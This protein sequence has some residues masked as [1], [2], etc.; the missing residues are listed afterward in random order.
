M[1][2]KIKKYIKDNCNGSYAPDDMD[3]L[4]KTISE[5]S[6]GCFS[7]KK[8]KRLMCH[9][10]E[11]SSG[12]IV[13]N[14]KNK[15]KLMT[16]DALSEMCETTGSESESE[17][18]DK[19]TKSNSVGMLRL[20]FLG[21]TKNPEESKPV[22]NKPDEKYKYPETES[23]TAICRNGDPNYGPFS[24][25]SVHDVQVDDKLSKKHK[26][27][28]KAFEYLS[29]IE[30]PEQR[31]DTWFEQRK[32]KI[33]A[34][35]G[36]MVVGVNH[37]EP[38]WKFVCKKVT[39]PPFQNNVFCYH[40]K[41]LE[42]IATMVY[43]YR[44]NVKV[45]EFGMVPHKTIDFLGA[46]PDGIVSPYKLDSKHLTREVGKM[47]EI[48]CPY[49]RKI[50]KVGNIKG[51]I[52]PIYYWVQVQLQLECCDLDEC[53]FWQCEIA[54]YDDM[55]DFEDDTDPQFPYLSKD[56]KM[57]KGALIQLLPFNDPDFIKDKKYE[58]NSD[59]YYDKV[60]ASAIFIYPPK[61]EMTP[62]D[63]SIWV[64]STCANIKTSHPQYYLD[65]VIYWKMVVTHNVTIPRDKEWFEEHL[66]M[67]RK[68]WKYV[69]Y[70][71][72]NQDKANIVFEYIESLGMK[73]RSKAECD[74]ND[75]IMKIYDTVCDEPDDKAPEKEHRKYAKHIAQIIK[76]TCTNLSK[77]DKV[78]KDKQWKEVYEPLYAGWDMAKIL[79]DYMASL[80][81]KQ[82]QNVN[83]ASIY[84]YINKQPGEHS[85][86]SDHKKYIKYVEDLIEFAE[87]NN[88]EDSD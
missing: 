86:N 78:Y 12:K 52:C 28:T 38:Q 35:D 68:M 36:G 88:K 5:K 84:S 37:Y 80:D 76:E 69:T 18:D 1:S 14:T 15:D 22:K 66:P 10:A 9:Y 45:T 43:E 57:E 59:R 42:A 24:T 29:S 33:T 81:D 39:D 63:V 83:V 20:G 67:Y 61:V 82:I 87:K 7:K 71:R 70:F 11:V 62:R 4:A 31:S 46:S 48:K 40:G 54:E 8:A 74:N 79:Y 56:T 23:I 30:Y 77:N 72:E 47:L 16:F 55:E 32:G 58:K 41:K 26:R 53:D 17:S 51:D 6:G 85:S 25:Q 65:R 19:Y 13:F 50:N 27:L 3:N 44:M 34:S 60:F 64:A 49:T 2:S 75:K 73:P 21:N